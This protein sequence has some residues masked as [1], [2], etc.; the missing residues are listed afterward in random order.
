MWNCHEIRIWKYKEQPCEQ[1]TK[2]R[3]YNSERDTSHVQL[4]KW[5]I[6]RHNTASKH[7]NIW[8]NS[9]SP[10]FA[11]GCGR[12]LCKLS[13]SRHTILYNIT[14]IALLETTTTSL[15]ML[16]KPFLSHFMLRHYLPL[17]SLHATPIRV[18]QNTTEASSTI[19]K[20][21]MQY[22]TVCPLRKQIQR[23]LTRT[24]WSKHCTIHHTIL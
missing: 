4:E 3:N 10:D 21:K 19:Q 6:S 7:I 2:K 22:N 12:E 13:P 14:F 1:L 15:L 8:N 5:N 17:F 16:C 20:C 23:V 24:A 11:S 9:S 18:K